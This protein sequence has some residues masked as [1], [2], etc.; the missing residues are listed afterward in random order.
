MGHQ[1]D[2]KQ[3]RCDVKNP[4][5]SQVSHLGAE[6]EISRFC[7]LHLHELLNGASG[8]GKGTKGINCRGI[9]T[10]MT[11]V[12]LQVKRSKSDELTIIV[13]PLAYHAK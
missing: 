3:D 7:S 6:E 5:G 11:V 12:K 10:N 4:T 2:Q 8:K 13:N 9:N 1:V